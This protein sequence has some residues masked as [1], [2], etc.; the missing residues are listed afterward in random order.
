M[1]W[2]FYF[3]QHD[4]SDDVMEVEEGEME[5]LTGLGHYMY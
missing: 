3:F 2:G 1:S 5:D 4:I